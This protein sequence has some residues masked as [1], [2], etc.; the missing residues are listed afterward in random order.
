MD[1]TFTV[2]GVQTV[3]QNIDAIVG[4]ETIPAVIEA[5]SVEL[6]S[7]HYGSLT[8]QFTGSE[9]D[10]AKAKFVQGNT[11]TWTI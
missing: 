9:K 6:V 3:S 5:F 2:H 10:E 7:D 4:G 11:V 1:I 8:L